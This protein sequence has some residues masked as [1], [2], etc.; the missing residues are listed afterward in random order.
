MTFSDSIDI[1]E[2]I[3][4]NIKKY[5][6]LV[7]NTVKGYELKKTEADAINNLVELMDNEQIL[8]LYRDGSFDTH[9]I[10][11]GTIIVGLTNFRI[12]KIENGLAW[13]TFMENIKSVKHE[14][15]GIFYWDKLIC[16]TKTGAVNTYG[17]YYNDTCKYF[18]DYMRKYLIDCDV[19]II[20]K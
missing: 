18:C 11:C 14:Q 16:T 10:L 3:N 4:N 13:S 20:I 2:Q 1:Q 8:L 12:F 6:H 5:S 15:N 9:D 17:I 7:T 19:K